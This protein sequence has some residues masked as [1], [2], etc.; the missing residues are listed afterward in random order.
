MFEFKPE[1]CLLASAKTGDGVEQ[2]LEAVVQRVTVPKSARDLPFRALIF[3]SW[4]EHF[5]GAITGVLVKD[6]SIE[7]G[8]EI[9]SINSGKAY[10][11]M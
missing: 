11:V 4:F 9:K 2:V 8:Q 6:G 3:D 1:D 5:K 10:E 7:R